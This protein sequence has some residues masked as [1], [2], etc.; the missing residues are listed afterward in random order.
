MADV[1]TDSAV[2]SLKGPNQIFYEWKDYL[3]FVK[4]YFAIRG[5]LN[6]VVVEIG[7][8]NG[9]QKPHYQKFLDA[10][11]IGIDISDKFCKPD[12]LGD[13]H[14]PETMARLKAMLATRKINLLFI[15]AC[16]TYEDALSEYESYGPLSKDIIAFHD[17][18]HIL[19]IGKLWHDINYK[20]RFNKN[21]VSFSIG[22][23]GGG[24][25]ELG[26]GVIVKHPRSE[27]N[28]VV[29]EFQRTRKE[30]LD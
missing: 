2:R 6:P 17:I 10:V 18:R 3:L 15:D 14:A 1:I 11:H 25:C 28:D 22:G 24:W 5:I 12:I 26:I 16:H 4:S 19:G 23:W 20:E 7:V 13:S 29:E 27:L 21:R 8:Q 30:S 9:R